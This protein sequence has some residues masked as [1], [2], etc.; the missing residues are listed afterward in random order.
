LKCVRNL[1]VVVILFV[2]VTAPAAT[3]A[4]QTEKAKP[5]TRDASPFPVVVDQSGDS[6]DGQ[7]QYH[8]LRGDFHIH[9]PHSD[10][11]LSPEERVVEAWEYGYDVIAITDHGN[12]KAYEEALPTAKALGLLLVRGMETG[13]HER[14]HL[15][16]LGL[17]ADYQPRNSHHWAMKTGEDR[18]YYRDQWQRLGDAGAFVLYPHP[19]VGLKEPTR[20]AIKKGL[21][22]GIEVMN[23]GVGDG[24]GSKNSHGIHWYPFALDW[25]VEHNL[26]VFANSDI[27][28]PRGK[29]P[30]TV[31][32]VLT[33]DRTVEGVMDALRTGRTV[34]QFNDM[35]CAREDVLSL[36]IDS[37]VDVRFRKTVEGKAWLSVENNGPVALEATV[38][39]EGLSEAEIALEPYGEVLV[40]HQNPATKTTITWENAWIRSDKNLVTVHR[41]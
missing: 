24:W 16:A 7:T 1:L 22:G 23:G 14:E 27:H 3:F 34:A 28:H 37:L 6:G 26:A 39:G 21:L 17:T 33:K 36:L 9:T 19:H 4:G 41:P 32:L 20:W 40:P 18:P 8:V 31:T 15:V 12:F 13:I 11:K 5:L 2:I 38:R 29:Q 35:L 10:G 30:R 25:A